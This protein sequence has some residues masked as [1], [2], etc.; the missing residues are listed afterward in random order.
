M[1]RTTRKTT[2]LAAFAVLAT[3]AALLAAAAP[4]FAASPDVGKTYGRTFGEWSAAWW[5]WL[6]SIPA[7]ENPLNAVDGEVDCTLGQSGPVWFLAGAAPGTTAVR[8]CT[9]PRGKAL[10]FPAVNLAFTYSPGETLNVVEK[11]AILD[12]VLNDT[13]PGFLADFGFPGSRVCEVGITLNGE[14]TLYSVPTARV[15]SPA[16]PLVASDEPVLNFPPGPVDDEA[17]SDGFWALLPPLSPGEHTL[18]ISGRF[19]EI[20][21]FETHPFFGALDVTYHLTV[22]PAAANPPR[23]PRPGTSNLELIQALYTAFAE[24]DGATILEL[25]D[26]DVV[27]IESEGIPYGGTFVG[28]DAVFEGVFNKI[29]A[30]WDDF[31]ATVDDIFEADGDRV[32]VKQRDGGTFKAT[33]KSMEAP[34]ISIWTLEAGRVI[35]FEQVIDTQEVMSA[36]LP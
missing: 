14:P 7:S 18:R 3:C 2:L 24:G 30:E 16:F 28:R 11:R 26:E 35:Q 6:L 32:I 1:L 13:E 22:A 21:S 9:V 10:F 5:Q 33:G 25:I 12:G 4:A 20:D 15:Q 19:C 17:V 23:P 8:S 34:A 29:A 31:T 27:W 36:V